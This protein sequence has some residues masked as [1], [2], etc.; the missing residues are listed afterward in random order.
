MEPEYTEVARKAGFQG[1]IVLK[2]LVDENGRPRAIR[3]VRPLGMGLDEA[4]VAAVRK[5]R[6]RPGEKDGKPVVTEATIEIG[7]RV[8]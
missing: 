5:W 4:A 8:L 7:F 2:L 6:F 1:T 3:T